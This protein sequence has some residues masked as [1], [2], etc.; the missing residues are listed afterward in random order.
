MIFKA[1]NHK[2]YQGVDE[3]T[4]LKWTGR[5]CGV[6]VDMIDY[7]FQDRSQLLRVKNKALRLEIVLKAREQLCCWW[8][9]C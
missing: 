3:I 8:W 1:R 6:D 7:I 9:W 2:E 5:I 4:I